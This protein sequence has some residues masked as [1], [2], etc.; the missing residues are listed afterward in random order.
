MFDNLLGHPVLAQ[1]LAAA[2]ASGNLPGGLLFS[3]PDFSGK[4]TAALELSRAL[5]CRKGQA[6]WN[7]SCSSCR[8]HRLLEHP[9]MMLIG[10]RAHLEELRAAAEMLRADHSP[11]VRYML[12]RAV[13]KL[14]R[15]FDPVLWEGANDRIRG[16]A[17]LLEELMDHSEAIAPPAELESEAIL[18]KRLTNLIESAEKLSTRLPTGG[19]PVHLVRNVAFWSR[20]S[21]S[22]GGP[23][24][25]IIDRAQQLQTS[26]ANAFL[27]ILEEP[28]TD[29]FFILIARERSRL[30]PTIL[31]R[32]RNY[33]FAD[34][35][36]S[37]EQEVL[38]RVFRREPGYY[39]R[40]RDYMHSFSGIDRDRM[41][42]T[43]AR[44]FE[45]VFNGE[46]QSGTLISEPLRL[47]QEGPPQSFQVFLE[48]LLAALEAGMKQIEN[49]DFG[50]G[51]VE[52]FDRMKRIIM[53]TGR[54]AESYNQTP[55]FLSET[56][57]YR[58]RDAV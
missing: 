53:E 34:R 51:V 2:V 49:Q 6:E 26:A 4:L 27:K 18:E 3:G 32:L 33:E 40:I 17:G 23:K 20:M 57:V 39:H 29:T 19:I 16:A 25:V 5:S 12:V 9:D 15:R 55:E 45:S 11:A 52:R 58:L 56:L 43:A 14:T 7:C 8:S 10:N 13:R 37:G 38:A 47:I 31:S 36:S 50:P 30:L 42:K 41:Q 54:M 35:G 48:E 28:P 46:K 1:E 22:S 21:A 44:L 24:T